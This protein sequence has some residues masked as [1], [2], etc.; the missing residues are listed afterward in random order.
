MVFGNLMLDHVFEHAQSIGQ[1]GRVYLG[2]L[3][4]TPHDPAGILRRNLA[5]SKA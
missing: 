1:M 4:L 5:L 2:G 3:N